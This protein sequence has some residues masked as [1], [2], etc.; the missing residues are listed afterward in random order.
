M[1]VLALQGD[2]AEHLAAL[3]RAGARAAAVKSRG[4]LDRIEGLVIPGGESTTVM[5]LLARFGLGEAIVARVRA[6]MPLWGTCMGMIVAAAQVAGLDQPSLGL[7]DVTVRRNAF[8]RQNESAEIDLPIPALGPRPF[9][10][11]F[12]RAPWIERS[13]P[14]VEVLAQRGGHG[15]MVRGGNVLGT[16]FHPELTQ[17]PR[18]HAYFLGM[19]AQSQENVGNTGSA[20]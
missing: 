20:A 4:E 2:F 14:S 6:G 9:P 18:V 7:L 3:E 15:V 17:D 19:V 11:I 12:I 1:G 13:G 16:S 5:K 8:G 10:A